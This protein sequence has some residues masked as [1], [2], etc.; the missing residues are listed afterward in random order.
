MIDS[1]FDFK[2]G[3]VNGP[4]E[5]FFNRSYQKKFYTS[6]IKII[7][8]CQKKVVNFFSHKIFFKLIYLVS[9]WIPM[10]ATFCFFFFFFPSSISALRDKSTVHALLSIVHILFNT[11]YKLKNIK[12]ES[13]GTIHTFKNYFVTIFSVFSFQFQQK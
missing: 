9:V 12:N 11:I 10:K 13:Y 8:N 4:L 5:H 6:F 7:K 1:D 3:L 2:N